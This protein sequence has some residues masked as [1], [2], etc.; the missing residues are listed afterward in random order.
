MA[1]DQ[2]AGAGQQQENKQQFGIR[3]IYVRDMSFEV[4]SAPA[5][6]S[7]EWKPEVSVD[8]DTRNTQIAEN[9]YETV[10]R[11]TVTAKQGDK[12]AYLCE[13]E[14]G[15]IFVLSGFDEKTLD[16][17][18]GSYCPAQLF[19]YAREAVSDMVTKGGFPQMVLAPVNFE[20]LHMQRRR[21]QQEQQQGASGQSGDGQAGN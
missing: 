10:V 8:L 19:P 21:K 11:V 5:V 2:A 6:F 1:E 16:A 20:A 4:P 14:Q 13:V 3:K 15:G 12:T 9:T 18:L 7:G 17:L